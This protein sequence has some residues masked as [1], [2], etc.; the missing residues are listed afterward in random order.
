MLG[1]SYTICYKKGIE[2]KAADA[3]SRRPHTEQEVLPE[4]HHI[5]S[6][7]PLWL[8]D[9]IQSYVDDPFSVALLQRMA[10]HPQS[11]K[12]FSLK[13]GVLR[14]DQCIWVGNKPLLHH[15]LVSAFHDSALGGHSGFPVTYKHVRQLFRWAGMRG[16]IK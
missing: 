13:A 12:K 14:L 9:I 15:K 8:D 1:L 16:F 6:A 4:L 5:S 10:I 7:Q 3:L 11:D 2:N